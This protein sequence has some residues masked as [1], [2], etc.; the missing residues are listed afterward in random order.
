M[1]NEWQPI[2][3]VPKD[4][5]MFLAWV[6]AENYGDDDDGKPYEK[7]ASYVDFGQ[8]QNHEFG[9]FYTNYCAPNADREGITHWMPLPEA[10][11]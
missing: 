6:Q 2:E 11:R 8:W 1:S 5:S 10:P 3:T 9:G 4:G 7:D